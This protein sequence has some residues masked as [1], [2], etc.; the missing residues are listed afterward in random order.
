MAVTG[1]A[2]IPAQLITWFRTIGIPLAE[3]YG[4]SENTGPD[5][6]RARSR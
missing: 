5:D 4:M 3:V 6:L 2:P 1:A